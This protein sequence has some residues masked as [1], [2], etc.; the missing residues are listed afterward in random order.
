MVRT[1]SGAGRA[2]A[3]AAPPS[4]EES[5]AEEAGCLG[6]VPVRLPDLESAEAFA[7]PSV[8]LVEELARRAET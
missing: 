2:V 3:E 5:D 8:A 4:Q 7:D 6:G 1:R